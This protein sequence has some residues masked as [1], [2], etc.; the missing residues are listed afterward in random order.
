MTARPQIGVILNHEQEPGEPAPRWRDMCDFAGAAE[1]VGVSHL[2]LVDHFGWEDDPF[3]RPNS[4][5]PSDLGVWEAWTTLAALAA[6]TQRI[7]LGTLVTCTRYRNPTLL[8]K[9]ADSVDEISSGRLILGLGAGDYPEEQLAF[10]YDTDRPVGHFE[11]ALAIVTGLL[12]HGSIDFDGTFYRAH[13]ELRPRGPTP[14]GPP[15][16]I[17]S[18][19]H[20][21]RVLGLV[22]R[23][24]DMWNGWITDRSSS[25][26]VPPIRD[27]VDTACRKAGREPATLRR[28]VAVA[29]AFGGPMA[30]RAG[31]MTGSD[32]EIA[33]ALSAFADVGIDDVQVRLFPNTPSS[34]ERLGQIIAVM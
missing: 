10:G 33:I 5:I 31:S 6:H 23:F 17:G 2:W 8:A 27:A 7:S 24:A 30:Q 15:I 18:L 4:T 16:L 13:A 25:R 9:M 22:A 20:G 19:G 28:S 1:S 32:E 12:R 21:P 26:S 3:E 34:V 14:G 29:V 11:E